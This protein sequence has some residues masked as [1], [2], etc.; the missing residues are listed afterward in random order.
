[1]KKFPIYLATIEK[2]NSQIKINKI[3]EISEDEY[4]QFKE[5]N[6]K[7]H[8]FNKKIALL[9]IVYSNSSDINNYS[10]YLNNIINENPI[11]ITINKEQTIFIF[12][13]H[14][15]NYLSSVTMFLNQ[16]QYYSKE[17]TEIID[18]KRNNLHSNSVAYKIIY[19]LRNEIQHKKFPKIKI[20]FEKDNSQKFQIR[21]YLDKNYILS[22]KKLKKYKDIH[23]L[24]NKIDLIK[25][26]KEM[27][28]CLNDLTKFILESE[29]NEIE[30][31]YNFMNKLK[32]EVQIRG[33]PFIL[34]D[35]ND[36]SEPIMEPLNIELINFLTLF[37]KESENY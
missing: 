9:S 27:N 10:N 18:K 12:L 29:I 21:I 33:Y 1:M 28:K 22:I 15:T 2:S 34:N 11:F 30:K 13:K 3:R 24:N 4:N 14:F 8:Q 16:I 26:I 36:T 25:L 20:N 23:E 7:L 37:L 35:P 5:T 6:Y 19:E 32:N 31:Y 17:K